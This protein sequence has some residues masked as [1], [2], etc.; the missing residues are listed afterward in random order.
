MNLYYEIWERKD[1]QLSCVALKRS[2]ADVRSFFLEKG[3][4]WK[5]D[6]GLT[7]DEFKQDNGTLT[8][9]N[10]N[11]AASLIVANP[12]W[13]CIQLEMLKKGV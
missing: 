7:V 6:K 1:G 13:A 5:D 8:P 11:C 3:V 4:T 2:L 10:K 12:E 9:W